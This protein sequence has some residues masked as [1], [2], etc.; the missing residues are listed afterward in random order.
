MM[1][2]EIRDLETARIAI[3]ASLTGHLV[4]ST[5]DTNNA[6][7]TITRL[8][9]MGVESYLL[10]STIKGV[11]AQ[12][13]VRRLCAQCSRPHDGADHWAQ[14]IARNVPQVEALGPPDIRQPR[15]CVEC[16]GTGYSWRTTI[17]ELLLV[18]TDIHRLILSATPDARID[19]AAREKGMT[20]MYASGA[21]KVWRGETTVE[22]V[23]RATRM[24]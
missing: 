4:L 18:N 6:A 11:L 20:S 5:L 17:A 22:E 23:L 8:I 7:A 16:S 19:E 10:A 14:S 21:R 13:L 12:R 9:D 24:G 15:G 3:Q 1:I 2:G